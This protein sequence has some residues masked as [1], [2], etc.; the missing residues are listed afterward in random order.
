ME[1]KKTTE[2][3]YLSVCLKSKITEILQCF[4]EPIKHH[5]YQDNM[6]LQSYWMEKDTD[7]VVEARD[8]FKAPVFTPSSLPFCVVFS[9]ELR[10]LG[11]L[12]FFTPAVW[13]TK[14]RRNSY[15]LSVMSL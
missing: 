12:L 9:E 1:Q 5:H 11:F 15:L 3:V 8:V 4:S 2:H 10:L 13:K 6:K 14:T 7:S